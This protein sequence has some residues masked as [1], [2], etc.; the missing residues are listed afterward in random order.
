MNRQ[1]R[2]VYFAPR[3][4]VGW[5]VTVVVGLVLLAVAAVFLTAALIAGFVIATVLL[6]RVWWLMRKAERARAKQYL[7]AEYEV[8]REELDRLRDS[9]TDERF[10]R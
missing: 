10:K 7:S 2:A 3:T 9:G 4:W 8:E 6:A 5:F 1:T